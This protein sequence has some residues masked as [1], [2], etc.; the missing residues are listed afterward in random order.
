MKAKE[1]WIEQTL[2]ALDGIQQVEVPMSLNDALLNYSRPKEV[3]MTASQ[4]WMIAASILV[5]L[6][7]NL[8]TI[9][10]YS[11]SSK[12]YASTNDKNIVYKEYFSSDY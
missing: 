11:K 2:S 5:L 3:R 6:A 4:K 10:Q 12:N 7:V 8:I 1:Y 9:T